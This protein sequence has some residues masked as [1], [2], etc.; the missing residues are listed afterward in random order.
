[1]PKVIHLIASG[2]LHPSLFP[3]LFHQSDIG[4]VIRVFLFLVVWF[5]L[6]FFVVGFFAFPPSPAVPPKLTAL[7]LI[8]SPLFASPP[9]PFS[10]GII[11]L[12]EEDSH[13]SE[14]L[15]S[16][17][18]DF[19]DGWLPESNRPRFLLFPGAPFF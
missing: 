5:F 2:F 3:F 17:P 4:T 10:R 12:E 9:P 1:V 11:K 14:V 19:Q 15:T 6:C 16:P 7:T 8:L 18:F 13:L